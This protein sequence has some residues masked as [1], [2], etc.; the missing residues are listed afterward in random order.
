MSSATEPLGTPPEDEPDIHTTAGKLADLYRR[1]DEAVHA[2]S[3]RAVEKQHAKGKKTA[4]ERIELL[5]DE[6]SFVELDELARHRSTNFGQEKN[7]PY[8]DGVVTGYGTVDGRPV[9]VFSQD[10]TVF[11]G[12]LGEVYG[13]KI[14]K[15][16]DLAIK[17]GRPIIGINEGGGARIQEGVVSLGLYGEIFNRNVK[18]SGVI[19]QISLIMGANA[20]GHV[21]SPA[22]TD[23][24]V[25]VDETSQ[26]FITGPDVVKT[27]TG[28]DVTFEELG[29]GRTHNTKSGVAHYLGSDD[30]DAIA[31]V[32]ELLS[33]LPQNNL[34]DAPVFEPSDAP[35]GFF[36]DVTDA[37]RELDTIIPDS[38]NTPYDMHEVITRVVDDGDFLEVHE[39]FAPNI[40]VGFGRVDGQSVGV[41]ANQ[42]TQF[43]GCLDIDASEKAA[44]FVRTCDAFNIPVLTF[45]DV[46]GFLPGTDQEWNG[47]IRRGAKLIYAYAEAT[48]PLVTIIT[49][50]AYGGAYDVM[51]SKHLGADINL[52]WP[53]AQVAVMGA[54]GAAN[55]VHRKT[56][57]K[58]ASE[59]QD[60]DA[61]R[62]ELIQ[63]Y[64][65]T[66]L[67]P[68]AAAER[69]YVDSVIVPAHTRGHV[70][71]ALSLLRNKRESLPPKKHGNIPL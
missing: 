62:A 49:R 27:V 23:F 67:N 45:V 5:L 12:S 15:V 52:A 44:R 63:E 11:G 32:K 71:R 30:E 8:G 68:Y 25:M 4:R 9:C 50:K 26:M 14:V 57:A 29:G 56:L 58:A 21:Y 24:V 34:S 16:M 6:N 28:E 10:V 38:P 69:G 3:A 60:V 66:L 61:L 35:A 36:D 37:D 65:D 54:Q 59:G 33:Y 19:P 13:E 64:E 2:G 70:A 48:V 41:V 31:Y 22:L 17:T 20:G 55:I 40:I 7:R 51:G 18:A 47:I 39:L 43:A 1:Y 53:T 42:P 46:P